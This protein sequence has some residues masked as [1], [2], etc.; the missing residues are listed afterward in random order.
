MGGEFR[1]GTFECSEYTVG[2]GAEADTCGS[3]FD[4]LHC[5]FYLEEAAFGGPDCDVGVVLVAEHCFVFMILR[6]YCSSSFR[7]GYY[8]VDSEENYSNK[9][10]L[11]FCFF[12]V[13]FLV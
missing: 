8:C 13:S 11:L 9:A 3:L 7:L 12:F 1:D 6:E 10:S 4:G 5:V 2:G